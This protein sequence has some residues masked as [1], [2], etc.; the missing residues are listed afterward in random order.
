MLLAVSTFFRYD[1]N[2]NA[3]ALTGAGGI[4]FFTS[5]LLLA[6]DRFVKPV[7]HGALIIM[8]TYH[9]AQIALVGG[10]LLQFGR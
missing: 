8:V 4:L 1:W 5:D 7:R 2:T 3:A 6:F 10:A 9:L